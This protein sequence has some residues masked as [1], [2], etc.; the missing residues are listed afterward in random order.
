[1][2]NIGLLSKNNN[3]EHVSIKVDERSGYRGY[4]NIN[5]EG[6]ENKNKKLNIP[7]WNDINDIYEQRWLK[8]KEA[9]QNQLKE[10]FFGLIERFAC[11]KQ[12]L[13]QLVAP[14]RRVQDYIKAFL[15]LFESG[16]A[17]HVGDCERLAGKKVR[18]LYITLPNNYHS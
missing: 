6:L 12:E 8:E 2:E 11:G 1:M 3:D 17:P 18:K 7:S 4:N 5:E 14:D 16:Y 15:E 10:N 13:F 9:F